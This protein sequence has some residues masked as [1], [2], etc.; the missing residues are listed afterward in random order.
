MGRQ[1]PTGVDAMSHEPPERYDIRKAQHGGW[2]VFDVATRYTVVLD[3]VAQTGLDV[4]DA[5]EVAKSLASVARRV[6]VSDA[7]T[8]H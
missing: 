2:E 8:P 6:A 4:R 3:G 7:S 5:D 1:A